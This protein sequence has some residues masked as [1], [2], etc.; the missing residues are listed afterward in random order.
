MNVKIGYTSHFIAG[1]WWDSRL[2]MSTYTVT[3]K[4]I[5]ATDSAQD[6][7]TALDRLRYMV[8]EYLV[9]TV[10]IKN[11]DQEQIALL[12]A[13]GIKIIALPEEPV[14]QIIGMMLYSK[15]SAVMEGCMLIRSIMLSSTAGDDVIYEH[16]A[17]ESVAPFDQPGWWSE[18]TPVC[19]TESQQPSNDTVF[20]LNAVNQWRDLGL[21]WVSDVD[22]DQDSNVL[23]F[24][25]FKNDKDK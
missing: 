18:P 14:D 15:L 6:T 11:T 10:F 20:V 12:K 24:T 5:T 4:M 23:V 2:I 9:D 3:F 1:V 8:E 22:P 19:E 17:Q 21:Q 13:A 7:N 25:E 16:D